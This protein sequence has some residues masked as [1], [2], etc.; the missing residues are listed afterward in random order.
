MLLLIC[1]CQ[2][3]TLQFDGSESNNTD[4]LGEVLTSFDRNIS[5]YIAIPDYFPSSEEVVIKERNEFINSIRDSLEYKDRALNEVMFLYEAA[6]N[7][8]VYHAPIP[9]EKYKEE[10]SAFDIPVQSNGK[11]NGESIKNGMIHILGNMYDI[12]LNNKYIG[13]ID[14]EPIRISSSSARIRVRYHTGLPYQDVDPSSSDYVHSSYSEPYGDENFLNLSNQAWGVAQCHNTNPLDNAADRLSGM[15]YGNTIDNMF[16]LNKIF[17]GFINKTTVP[18]PIYQNG[19]IFAGLIT[20]TDP[21]FVN[22]SPVLKRVKGVV[23]AHSVFWPLDNSPSKM[24]Y[25]FY[26]NKHGRIIVENDSGEC[27]GRGTHI[28]HEELVGVSTSQFFQ[29]DNISCNNLMNNYIEHGPLGSNIW[30]TKTIFYRDNSFWTCEKTK[31]QNCLTGCEFNDY[32]DRLM[33]H[34]NSNVVKSS[35]TNGPF[36]YSEFVGCKVLPVVFDDYCF[37]T[38]GINGPPPPGGEGPTCHV[39]GISH[40]Y[41]PMVGRRINYEYQD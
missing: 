41:Y 39:R 9:L 2:K 40:M 22:I 32:A 31:P 30:I 19:R 11:I 4:K 5:E 13:M 15:F 8:D 17:V 37:K 35:L 23:N 6:V 3:E 18:L 29:I 10:I 33:S 36:P 25:E 24:D 34:I 12:S 14:V 7:L 26:L 38:E 1:G 16:K 28:L 20:P 21:I 27:T